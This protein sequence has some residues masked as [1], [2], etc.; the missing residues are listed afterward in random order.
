M[1]PHWYCNVYSFKL[2]CTVFMGILCFCDHVIFVV[3]LMFGKCC[4]QIYKKNIYFQWK[5]NTY[6]LL[7]IFF[8]QIYSWHGCFSTWKWPQF[9]CHISAIILHWNWFIW[10]YSCTVQQS[11]GVS[12]CDFHILWCLFR[13]KVSK[14]L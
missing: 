6:L 14:S 7:H 12:Y 5:I 11:K 8:I 9:I 13:V 3:S 4:S 2:F 1:H 10:L